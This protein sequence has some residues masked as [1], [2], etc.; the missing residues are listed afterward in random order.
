MRLRRRTAA[1]P[2]EADEAAAGGPAR[3]AFES[4]ASPRSAGVEGAARV[5]RDRPPL[6]SPFAAPRRAAPVR[7]ARR[8]AAALFASELTA[9]FRFIAV[10]GGEA[11]CTQRRADR[12]HSRSACSAIVS[13]SGRSSWRCS[14]G[15][16][17]GPRWRIAV[18]RDWSRSL[19][20]LIRRPAGRQHTSARSATRARR[21]A[22]RSFFD[23]K[24]V[25]RRFW[26]RDGERPRSRAQR[27]RPRHSGPGPARPLRPRRPRRPEAGANP[28]PPGRDHFPASEPPARRRAGRGPP[29]APAAVP[30]APARPARPRSPGPAGLGDPGAPRD[31]PRTH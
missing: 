12:H 24:A 5:S 1:A 4:A 2:P 15:L 21:I 11:L 27:R 25:R 14:E 22:G 18:A 3:L 28:Q 31:E 17:A 29:P 13:P 9:T 19:V 20:F 6:R 10:R 30:D 16:E 26:L 8:A 23:A 7:R